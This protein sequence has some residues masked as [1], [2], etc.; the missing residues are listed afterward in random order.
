MPASY[1]PGVLCEA[2]TCL[3]Q[4]VQIYLLGSLEQQEGMKGL[5]GLGSPWVFLEMEPVQGHT[6]SQVS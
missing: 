1:L 2:A 5:R 4:T 3:L 6:E